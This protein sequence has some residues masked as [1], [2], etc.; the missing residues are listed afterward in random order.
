MDELRRILNAP[1]APAGHILGACIA[2]FASHARDLKDLHLVERHLG[3]FPS[4]LTA[5]NQTVGAS[6]FDEERASAFVEYLSGAGGDTLRP[7]ITLALARWPAGQ[8]K[9]YVQLLRAK[10]ASAFEA[11]VAARK[12]IEEEIQRAAAL[13]KRKQ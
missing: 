3:T 11:V 2:A 13:Q 5:V 8:A 7:G 10:N 6:R 12:R 1:D 4:L 9:H